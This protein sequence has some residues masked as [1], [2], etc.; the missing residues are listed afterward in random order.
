MLHIYYGLHK[1]KTEQQMSLG[2]KL[3]IVF[4]KTGGHVSFSPELQELPQFYKLDIHLS[5]WIEPDFHDVEKK[6]L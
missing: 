2:H 6:I 1:A 5:D 4:R 3:L